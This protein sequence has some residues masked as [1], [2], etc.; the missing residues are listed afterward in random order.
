LFS[1]QSR[2]R[3]TLALLRECGIT[4]LD[5]YEILEIGCGS[6]GVLM[7]YLGYGAEARRLYGVDLLANR[8]E[9]ARR[10]LPGSGLYCADGQRLPF[11]S[12]RFDLALQY[13][14]FSSVL[15]E[16]IRRKMAE[17]MLRVVKPGGL[18][19]WYDFWLNPTNRQT[20]GIRPGEVRGLF[21]GCNYNFHKITLAPPLARRIAPVSWGLAQVLEGMKIFN[22]H[23]LA[24]IR[25]ET[26]R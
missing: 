7:E 26:A 1:A 12:G 21:P 25:K 9:E 17:E 2:Q 3:N 15:D 4:R 14:A 5:G 20:R 23:Y 22:S 10:R 19:V 11:A 16:V 6:G 13:T 24:A 18:V 8:L